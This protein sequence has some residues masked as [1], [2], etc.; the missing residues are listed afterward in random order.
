MW[1][2]VPM[3]IERI[4][5]LTPALH[6]A[7]AL[8]RAS[9]GL[10]FALTL[11]CSGRP[12]MLLPLRFG[13][14]TAGTAIAFRVPDAIE[15]VGQPKVDLPPLHVDLDHLHAHLVAEPIHLVRV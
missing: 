10:V 13:L 15:N 5:R 1:P 2:A 7:L 4:E 12:Q 3:T 6:C 11:V 8:P 9:F 14:R